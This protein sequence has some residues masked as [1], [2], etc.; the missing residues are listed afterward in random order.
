MN[1]QEQLKLKEEDIKRITA[2]ILEINNNITKAKE[3]VTILS[4]NHDYARGQIDLLKEMIQKE[5]KEE[6]D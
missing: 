1:L 5:E 4:K 3:D 6:K 2:K